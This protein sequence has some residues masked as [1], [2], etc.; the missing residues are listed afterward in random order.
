MNPKL[1]MNTRDTDTL[2]DIVDGNLGELERSAW[3]AAHPELAVEVA[4][5]LRVRALLKQ[6]QAAE[7][8]VPAGFEARLLAQI[9]ADTTL[10]DLLDL[11][12]SGAGRAALELLSLFFALAPASAAPAQA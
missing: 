8:A 4:N 1:G 12:L 10:L 11:C 7:I 2:I 3:L 5:A 6:L 9:S